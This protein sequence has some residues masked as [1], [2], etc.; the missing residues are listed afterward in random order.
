MAFFTET[1]ESQIVSAIKE[2]EKQTSGEIR[3]HVEGKTGGK[4][5]YDRAVEVFEKLNMHQTDERNGILFYVATKDHAFSLIGD[6]GIHEKVGDS[7]WGEVRD[8]VIEEFKKGDF[9]EGLR[10]GITEAGEQLKV[11]FPYQS[12]DV[13]ELPDD[14]SKGD[15]E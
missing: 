6:I 3:V 15:F 12:D 5:S 1:Q 4:S 9:V 14:I 7:F 13:N 11:H 10:R 8:H 2:A